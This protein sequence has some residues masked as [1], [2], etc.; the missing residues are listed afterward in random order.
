MQSY[1][2]TTIREEDLKNRVAPSGFVVRDITKKV[3]G[4]LGEAGNFSA[5][6]AY[7]PL[8]TT[9]SFVDL[10]V[11]PNFNV[12]NSLLTLCE[13]CTSE[14]LRPPR[15]SCSAVLL[16]MDFSLFCLLEIPI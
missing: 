13:F 4:I 8:P 2:P 11:L 10:C 3:N 12:H 6:I 9:V 16:F 1:Y 14:Y 7:Y 15:E 5:E